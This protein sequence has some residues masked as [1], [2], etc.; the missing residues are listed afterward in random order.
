MQK[1]WGGLVR[2]EKLHKVSTVF[3]F[4]KNRDFW[5][6]F[7]Y[8]ASLEG[9]RAMV[10]VFLGTFEGAESNGGVRI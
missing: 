10:G 9:V 3:D 8:G 4:F 5:V 2:P 7:R 6:F 1:F